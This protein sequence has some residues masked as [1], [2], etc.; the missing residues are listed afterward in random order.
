MDMSGFDD[1]EWQALVRRLGVELDCSARTHKAFQR[2]RGVPNAGALLRLA[3]VHGATPSSLRSTAGWAS[4]AGVASVSDVALLYRLQACEAWLAWIFRQVLSAELAAL[5]P[6]PAGG[7][8]RLRAIDGTVVTHDDPAVHPGWRL[9]ASYDLAAGRFD[10]LQLTSGREGERPSRFAVAPGDIL[11]GDRGFTGSLDIFDI[12]GRGG[13]FILHH[14]TRSGNQVGEPGRAACSMRA[15]THW[16]RPLF[17][18]WPRPAP[19]SCK[20]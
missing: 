14:R 1:S 7:G 16:T 13:A 17:S 10:D 9:H 18:A 15:A 12:A 2:P 19:M 20:S 3:L 5:S 8:Y 11:V 4:A 6:L